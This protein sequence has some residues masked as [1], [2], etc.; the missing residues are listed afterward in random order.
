MNA[1]VKYSLARLALAIASIALVWL[2]TFSWVEIGQ[3]YIWLVL[4]LGLVLSSISSIFMLSGLRD[5]VAVS[6]EKR[7]AQMKQ[8]FEESRSAEDID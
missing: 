8:R 4:L 5:Q 2:V 1:F 7:G 3:A 6:L